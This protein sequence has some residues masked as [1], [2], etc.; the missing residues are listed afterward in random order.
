LKLTLTLED[1]LN[2]KEN[3][4]GFSVVIADLR[5]VDHV[6]FKVPRDFISIELQYLSLA[7]GYVQK[8]FTSKCEMTEETSNFTPQQ[9]EDFNNY[10]W[11]PVL[12]DFSIYGSV[13]NGG[14]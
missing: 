12:D 3:N 10:A 8:E 6:V 4:F 1:S 7:D 14:N 2:L 11:C 5:R 9:L 13:I